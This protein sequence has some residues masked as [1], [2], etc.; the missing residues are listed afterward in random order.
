[1]ARALGD[2][3]PR[4]DSP[5]TLSMAKH[6][7]P[8]A[9]PVRAIDTSLLDDLTPYAPGAG[10]MHM[11]R[12]HLFL[13]TQRLPEAEAAFQAALDAFLAID[14]RLGAANTQRARGHLFLRTQRLPEAEAAFQA[15]LDSYLDID[16]RLGVANTH[17]ARGGLFLRTD[18]IPEAEA[19]FQAARLLP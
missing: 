18:R 2:L 5:F 1:M 14:H 17:K 13:R 15:A 9:P 7:P 8:A 10:I 19:A 11:A 12:G 6:T 3:V 16:H 4:T